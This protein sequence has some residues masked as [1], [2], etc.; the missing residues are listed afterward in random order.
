VLLLA[1]AVDT[2]RVD[3]VVATAMIAI[4]DRIL[5]FMYI[6]FSQAKYSIYV[7]RLSSL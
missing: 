2:K 4:T 1:K 5:A 6:E 3:A 7:V